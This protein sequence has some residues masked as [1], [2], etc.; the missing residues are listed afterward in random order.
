MTVGLKSVGQRSW[1]FLFINSKFG[2][3]DTIKQFGRS[4]LILYR[5]NEFC[6]KS[7]I[8]HDTQ[9]KEEE[10]TEEE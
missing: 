3:P 9:L 5:A 2:G 8:I 1:Y 4:L 7:F 10:G 6:N